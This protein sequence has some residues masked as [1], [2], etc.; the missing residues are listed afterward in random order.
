MSRFRDDEE[1]PTSHHGTWHGMVLHAHLRM[2]CAISVNCHVHL[3]S[4]IIRYHPLGRNLSSE[5][6]D[7]SPRRT[8]PL[9]ECLPT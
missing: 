7:W 3:M 6:S 2:K 1:R 8:R 9:Y 4:D 5:Q